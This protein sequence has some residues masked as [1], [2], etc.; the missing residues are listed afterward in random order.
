MKRLTPLP[1]LF[2]LG[3]VITG[4]TVGPRYK[5]PDVPAA[6]DFRGTDNTP[7]ADASSIA[8]QRWFDVFHD[9]DLQR[10]IR[11]ALQSNFDLRIAAQQ[12]LEQQAQVGITRSQQF[13]TVTVGGSAVGARLGNAVA[14]SLNSPETTAAGGLTLSAA[15]T[16]DFWGL[17]RR[18]TEAARAQ[19]LAQQWAQKAVISTLV[20]NVATAYIQLRTLDHELATTRETLRVRRESLQLTERL[21]SGGWATLS[22]VREAQALVYTASSNIPALEQRIQQQENEINLLLGRKP[23]SVARSESYTPTQNV[24]AVPAGI[25][26]QLLERRP[27]IQEAEAILI[28]A[29][30]NIGVARAQFFPSLPISANGGVGSNAFNSLFDASGGLV[31]GMGTLTQPLFVGGRLRNNLRLAKATDQ[32]MVIT[33]QKAI[34]TAFRDV[35]NA[36]I[37]YRKTRDY[38]EEQQGL[39]AADEDA[40]RLAELRYQAG[41]TAYLEVLTNEANRY[42][43]Q[44]SLASAQQSEALSLVQL[45]N[46]LGGGWQ[47]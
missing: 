31:Y 26:S 2:L 15:W 6:P 11:E 23:G 4:C 41:S 16:P 20:A 13:P 42:A 7:V 10:L 44:L 19:F 28:A 32:E 3:A 29:N 17:Y 9:P 25:P 39:V 38:R 36:L 24:D 8:D 14:S 1:V 5:R 40:T 43:A 30:A 46:A 22:D 37:A 34:D 45:Y 47:P 33:Y 21:E 35:S 18:Q 12:V 27:D